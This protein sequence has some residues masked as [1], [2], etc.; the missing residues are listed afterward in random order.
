MTLKR[1]LLGDANVRIEGHRE[2]NDQIRIREK[3]DGIP[4][5]KLD[6]ILGT[7]SYFKYNAHRRKANFR[8][9]ARAVEFFGGTLVIDWR[10]Q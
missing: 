1:K 7:G 8:A 9:V 2:L 4:L 6:D 10:D 5:Y 3:E